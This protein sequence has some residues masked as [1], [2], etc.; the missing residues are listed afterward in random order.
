[1]SIVSEPL[2]QPANAPP[3]PAEYVYVAERGLLVACPTLFE[4]LA[5]HVVFA[6]TPL[7]VHCAGV[8]MVIVVGHEL[9]LDDHAMVIGSVPDVQFAVSVTFCAVGP[10]ELGLADSEQPAG[11][12]PAVIVTGKLALCV[13]DSVS[14][15]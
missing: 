14:T 1:L 2:G 4:K 15:V 9:A 7:I 12:G 13:D 3:P 5:V 11:T 10:P 6:A 8:P